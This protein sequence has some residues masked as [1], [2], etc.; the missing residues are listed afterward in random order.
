MK[1]H[2]PAVSVYRWS[3]N[4]IWFPVLCLLILC[5]LVY[6][7]S[8]YACSSWRGFGSGLTVFPLLGM[9]ALNLFLLYTLN[10]REPL[11]GSQDVLYNQVTP[12]SWSGETSQSPSGKPD[13]LPT[14]ILDTQWEGELRCF[15]SFRG[16]D[17]SKNRP[18]LW[19]AVQHSNTRGHYN[20]QV[21]DGLTCI[22]APPIQDF[23]MWIH[24]YYLKC[25]SSFPAS[26][27]GSLWTML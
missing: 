10:L 9:V 26:G 19:S 17:L 8:L 3:L 11:F 4:L 6:W 25:K 5:R 20:L 1:H 12:S 13:I 7:V 23:F 15:S 24:A 16:G 14:D 2:H 22:F 27:R 21:C 18:F